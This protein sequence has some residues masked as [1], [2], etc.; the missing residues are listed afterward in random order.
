MYW[1]AITM[2]TGF[3]L[4]STET[5]EG[6]EAHQSV[7]IDEDR[8]G[9]PSIL[10]FFFDFTANCHFEGFRTCCSSK[11]RKRRKRR[12]RRRQLFSTNKHCHGLAEVDCLATSGQH[13]LALLR[14]SKHI[15]GLT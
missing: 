8:D 9:L 3:S 6:L 10:D 1:V 13:R 14:T 4:L 12:K 2:A 15:A 5:H 11:K 7:A